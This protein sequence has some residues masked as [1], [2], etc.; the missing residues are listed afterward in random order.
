MKAV[1]CFQFLSG[2]L[3]GEQVAPSVA[4]G[5]SAAEIDQATVA[6]AADGKWHDVPKV[7]GIT[8][9]DK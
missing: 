3:T 5:W 2:V 1:E 6:S 7:S 9:Y 8:T 4:D